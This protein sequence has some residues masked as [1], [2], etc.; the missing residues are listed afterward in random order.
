MTDV[1]A[2]TKI[3]NEILQKSYVGVWTFDV[4]SDGDLDLILGA[5]YGAPIVLQNNS[6]GSFSVVKIF[7]KLKNIRDFVSADLT[8]TATAT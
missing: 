1:T 5:K 3:S 2:N 8:K 7:P 4:E 6:D